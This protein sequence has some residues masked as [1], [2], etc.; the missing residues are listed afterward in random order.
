VPEISIQAALGASRARIVRQLLAESVTIAVAAGGLG[1]LLALAG[2][3]AIR[4]FGP[5]DLARLQEVAVDFRVLG[6]AAAISLSTGVLV[7][8]A[9][10]AALWRRDLRAGDAG[11]C[12]GCWWSPSAPP[13]SCCW[14]APGCSSA[15]GGT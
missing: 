7:A 4:A 15:A 13:L 3:R 5:G 9:P 11:G 8:L 10:A 1:L 2:V 6:W 12:V 14:P